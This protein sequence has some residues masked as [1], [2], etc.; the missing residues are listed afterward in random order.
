MTF[1]DL[2]KRL[3][4]ETAQQLRLFE[5]LQGKPFW[6]WDRQQHKQK[7]VKTIG[8][9]C[10]NHIIGLPQKDGIDKP[11]H[12]YEQIIFDS[13]VTQISN[14]H[15]WIKKATGLG[16]SEFMLRFMAWLCLKDNTLSGSQ[17]CIVTGPR[18]DLAIALIDRMKKL[19]ASGKG[20]AAAIVFDTRET[21]IELNNVKIEAFPSH[22][23]D[24]MRGL[25]NVSFIL[26]DE[27]DFFPPGQQQ[28][29]RDVSER[30]IAKSNPHIVMVST[31]NAPEGLFERIEK[32]S[33]DTCLYKRILLDYTYGI[34][35]IYSADE[36]KKAKQS[37]SFEREYNL[38]YLGKIGN[39]FHTK[40]I[41]AAIEKGRKYDPDNLNQ[42]IFTSTSMGID[43]A[44]GSSAFG[45]VITRYA[46]G[47]VQILYAEEYHR[48]DYNEMLSMVY[49]LMTKYNVD[50]VYIDG[51]NPSFIRS[52][53]LQIGEDADY[54]K[55]IARY[56]S[57]GFGDESAL[58][59]MKVIPVNFNKEHK[60]MLGHCKMIIE[61]DGG[62][63]AINPDR[64]DKLITSLRTAVDNDGVL[65]KEATSY[66][67][68][69][70]AFRLALKFYHFEG[71]SR[72][73]K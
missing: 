10:F 17:M 21:I 62:R 66:N 2:K 45:I 56:R 38:K 34:G 52:L 18:I 73:C 4:L 26:L 35:K 16:V 57:E 54:D 53:K 9:C 7:A 51:A 33:E 69:F 19:F 1:K 50:K 65:D 13:L 44:Y 6:I 31:P 43:P 71:S 27:A 39:V 55:V 32:E 5:R 61:N 30:Y 64:Y 59:D 14:K 70:D 12:D 58:A 67:D 72:I 28:D 49:G 20:I 3:S 63:I 47:I 36:I 22:H 24:A 11:L 23:L 29:A 46:D 8:D 41:E 37:P 48:P 60:A 68:I 40:D 15:L 25:P 42:S